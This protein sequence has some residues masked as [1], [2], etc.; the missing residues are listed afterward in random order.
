MESHITSLY[1]S[2]MVELPPLTASAAFDATRVA[3]FPNRDSGPGSGCWVVVASGGTLEVQAESQPPR[4]TRLCAY[5]RAFGRMTTAGGWWSVP[6]E[7][8][9]SPWSSHRCSVGIRPSGP[10]PGMQPSRLQDR[11]FEA[12]VTT[13]SELAGQ[14]ERHVARWIDRSLAA[15]LSEDASR[16]DSDA[17][18]R[19]R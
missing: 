8:E 1:V 18:W 19:L 4:T 7:V 13:A 2:A 10:R 6:I 11:Y 17:G 3:P 5:R 15:S 12:A 16:R 9:L 14:L